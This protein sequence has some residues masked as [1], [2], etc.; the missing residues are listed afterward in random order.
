M[1]RLS[2]DAY[3]ITLQ[4]DVYGR[5][6]KCDDDEEVRWKKICKFDDSREPVT[7]ARVINIACPS[8]EIVEN[9][10]RRNV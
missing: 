4:D 7:V 9:V 10:R 6:S 2:V 5:D 8:W 3:V 1:R